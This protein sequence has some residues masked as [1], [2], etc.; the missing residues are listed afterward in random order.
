MKKRYKLKQKW[1]VV[2]FYLTLII[3]TIALCR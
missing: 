2:I 3:C 1:G